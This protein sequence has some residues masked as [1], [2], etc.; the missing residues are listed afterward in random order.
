M[1]AMKFWMMKLFKILM[2]VMCLKLNVS[3]VTL[4]LSAILFL[5]HFK[6]KPD[7]YLNIMGPVCAFGYIENNYWAIF[8]PYYRCASDMQR[9][10]LMPFFLSSP[11]TL[12]L[13]I[14]PP[15]E[16]LK[17][18]LTPELIPVSMLTW[19][20]SYKMTQIRNLLNFVYVHDD[21]FIFGPQ[22]TWGGLK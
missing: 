6:T 7:N 21:K 13:H 9:T 10:W 1:T 2:I 12:K 5:R 14:T 4:Y 22:F 3:I 16:V 19:C 17:Y 11:G 15:P 20:V 18:C 8:Y